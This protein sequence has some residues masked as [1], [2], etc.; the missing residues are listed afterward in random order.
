MVMD[1]T[2][3]QAHMDLDMDTRDSS[4]TDAMTRPVSTGFIWHFS[5][6]GSMSTCYEPGIPGLMN[7]VANEVLQMDTGR[8]FTRP[9]SKPAG[10]RTEL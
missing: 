10:F 6:R 1:T 9:F 3:R 4:I 5:P 8:N 7:H 2:I